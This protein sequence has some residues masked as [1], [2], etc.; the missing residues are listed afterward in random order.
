MGI[1]SATP[2]RPAAETGTSQG[3][4]KGAS[5]APDHRRL[6]LPAGTGRQRAATQGTDVQR[7][8]ILQA[9]AD[10]FA[11]QGYANTTMAQIV[12]ALGVTKPFVYYYFRDKQ[13]IFE[14]L[15]WK[16]TVECLTS[17]DFAQDDTRCARDKVM[18]GLERLIRA[19]IANFPCAFFPYREPQVYR[20]EYVAEQKRIA[21][22]FYNRLVP[23]LEEARRDGDLD[24]DDPKLTA[25]AACSL[26]GFLYSWYK[27]DGRYSID[28]L[29]AKLCVLT[30]RLIGLR[31]PATATE[32]QEGS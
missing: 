10:L 29:V 17:M 24:F 15:S 4:G 8:R 9:A 1:T 21:H 30:W 28:D 14:T 16:P 13:E 12:R 7:E 22:H 32:R 31:Q 18:D 27:P 3:G 20:P 5:A 25:L 2:H 6:H 19:T 11:A 26:P 23:L